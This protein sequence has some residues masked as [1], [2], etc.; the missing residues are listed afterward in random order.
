MMKR[1]RD[2]DTLGYLFSKGSK[3]GKIDYIIWVV[4]TIVF[5]L[6]AAYFI[7]KIPY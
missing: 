5:A 4:V 6:I 3:G 2:L 7:D 1:N